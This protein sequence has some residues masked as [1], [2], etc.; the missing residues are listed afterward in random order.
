MKIIMAGE[1]NESQQLHLNEQKQMLT[2]VEDELAEEEN[3]RHEEAKIYKEIKRK[4]ERQAL[5]GN[6]DHM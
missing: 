1:L 3:K 5:L 2:E 4:V 6:P